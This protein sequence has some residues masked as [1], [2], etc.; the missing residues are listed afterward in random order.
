M[1]LNVEIENID[2]DVKNQTLV[3]WSKSSEDKYEFCP[4]EWRFG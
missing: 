2:A 3:I 4:F 1:K